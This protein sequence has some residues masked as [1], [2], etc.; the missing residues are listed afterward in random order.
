M[1]LFKRAHQNDFVLFCFCLFVW[2]AIPFI[3]G[4][5]NI[6]VYVELQY[7]FLDWNLDHY[8]D[9]LRVCKKILMCNVFVVQSTE[10]IYISLEIDFSQ[11]YF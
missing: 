3:Y 1:L 5:N 7:Q 4:S 11:I 10:L 9:I 2:M 8:I 6:K